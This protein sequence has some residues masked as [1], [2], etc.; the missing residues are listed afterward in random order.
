MASGKLKTSA[1]KPPVPSP[2]PGNRLSCAKFLQS[3]ESIG[4]EDMF[5]PRLQTSDESPFTPHAG[6]IVVLWDQLATGLRWPLPLEVVDFR[7]ELGVA[8]SQLSS[9]SWCDWF[10]L[11][12]WCREN[13]LF[14]SPLVFQYFYR[15]ISDDEVNF[16]ISSLVLLWCGVFW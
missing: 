6:K 15:L 5:F 13:E 8:P 14:F 4:L 1:D 7:K 3:L 12:I 9:N 16:A 2:H 11:L 10:T